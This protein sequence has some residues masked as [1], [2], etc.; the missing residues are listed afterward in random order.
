MNVRRVAEA[1]FRQAALALDEHELTLLSCLSPLSTPCIAGVVYGVPRED[2]DGQY[3]TV[4]I[5]GGSESSIAHDRDTLDKFTKGPLHSVNVRNRKHGRH[6]T[7]MHKNFNTPNPSTGLE[8]HVD[9]LRTSTC[10]IRLKSFHGFLI[11]F[12][13]RVFQTTSTTS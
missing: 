12:V 2:H 6:Q 8:D 11:N 1:N 13:R 3:R 9:I 7:R 10:T 4:T 5:M